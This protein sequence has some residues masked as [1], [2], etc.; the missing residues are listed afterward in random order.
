MRR[1]MPFPIKIKV[2]LTKLKQASIE[3]GL[4]AEFFPD[5]NPTNLPYPVVPFA[6][7]H[8]VHGTT[9]WYMQVRPNAKSN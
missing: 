5:V 4:P 9:H 8:Q 1:I 2:Y 7:A 6:Q 3:I